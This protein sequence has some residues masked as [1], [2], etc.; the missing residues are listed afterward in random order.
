MDKSK[1]IVDSVT[2]I[3]GSDGSIVL[4]NSIKNVLSAFSP[5]RVCIPFQYNSRTLCY[6]YTGR[7]VPIA[8]EEMT[9]TFVYLNS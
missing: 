5:G 3:T 8:G 4:L 1:I 7:L 2:D 6:V 9:I